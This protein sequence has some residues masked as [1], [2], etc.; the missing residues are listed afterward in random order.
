M[1][2]WSYGDRRWWGEAYFLLK[3]GY[4]S[5]T[6][7]FFSFAVNEFILAATYNDPQDTSKKYSD[8]FRLLSGQQKVFFFRLKNMG[9]SPE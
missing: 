6:F 3:T 2:W 7:A 8:Q 5:S 1:R 9:V 4:P